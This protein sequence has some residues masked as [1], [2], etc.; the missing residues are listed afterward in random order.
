MKHSTIIGSVFILFLLSVP[1]L[2]ANPTKPYWLREGAY[3]TYYA[4]DDEVP[5]TAI[6]YHEGRYYFILS[7]GAIVNFTVLEVGGDTAK[8][9]VE[10]VLLPSQNNDSPVKITTTI[11]EEDPEEVLSWI[12]QTNLTVK[13]GPPMGW[14]R[15]HIEPYRGHNR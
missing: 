4:F 12:N 9:E 11:S 10:V 5:A 1:G 13:V 15:R 6:Y 2:S 14:R 7:S 8:I 3:L